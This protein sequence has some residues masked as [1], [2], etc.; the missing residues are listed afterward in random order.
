MA[1]SLKICGH[2]GLQLVFE[3][4]IPLGSLSES[5]VETM[6]QRLQARHLTDC[7]VVGASL[8]KGVAGYRHDL[9]IH[10]DRRGSFAL[11]TTGTAFHY[12]ATVEETD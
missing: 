4:K 1:K 10:R 8:R 9:E 6:L 2:K 5:E 7:E 12:T 11:M 3:K